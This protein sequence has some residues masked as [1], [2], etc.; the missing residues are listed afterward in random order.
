MKNEKK[1]NRIKTL[2]ELPCSICGG[3]VR[4]K[5][6]TQVFEREGGKVTI[7]GLKVSVCTDCGKIYFAPGSADKLA[8]AV[9]DLF[10]LATKKRRK[11]KVLA[12]IS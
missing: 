11:G 10:A 1:Q 8:Q 12:R 9:N 7:S 5:A 4:R 3:A 2:M 6:V